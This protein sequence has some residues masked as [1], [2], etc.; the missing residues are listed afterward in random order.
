LFL[1][2]FRFRA[3]LF[4]FQRLFTIFSRLVGLPSELTATGLLSSLG[5]AFSLALLGL[6]KKKPVFL[7]LYQ[8]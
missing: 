7:Y 1:L 8:M 5:C 4:A 2:L 6:S 3:T